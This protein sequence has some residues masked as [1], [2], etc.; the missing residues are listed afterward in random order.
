ME[1]LE[2]GLR[3][4]P[5]NAWL[6]LR[7][8]AVLA[9]QGRFGEARPILERLVA[10][11]PGQLNAQALLVQ[12]LLHEGSA[13]GAV[14]QLQGVLSACPADRRKDLRAIA[15]LVA[16]ALIEV[17]EILAA[18]KHLELALT[19]AGD[20]EQRE[21]IQNALRTVESSPVHSDVFRNPDTLSPP[22]EGLPAHARER[23]VQALG[24]AEEGRWSDAASAF[25]TLATEKVAVAERNAGL[26]RLWVLDD[27]EGVVA[28]RRYIARL[29]ETEEAVDLESLCQVCEPARD[30]DL[31]DHFQLIWHIR[32]R[33]RLLETLKAT[34]EVQYAGPTQLQEGE[35]AF[36]V[37]AFHLLDRPRP[38]GDALPEDVRDLPRVVAD[39]LVG[40]D[41]VMLDAYDDG[42][43]DDVR[44]RFTDLV[45]SSIPPAH[46]RTKEL[47]R[48][49][50]E[51]RSMASNFWRPENGDPRVLQRLIDEEG[52]RLIREVWP[53][54]PQARFRGRTPR[55]AAKAGDARVPLRAEVSRIEL[56]H[57]TAG[58]TQI[59]FGALRSELGLTEEPE[60]DP[61]SVA[62]DQVHITRLHR[63]PADR[64]DDDRLVAL[65]RRARRFGMLL[66]LEGAARVI[67]DR[68]DRV[69]AKTVDRLE[70]FAVLAET[71]LQRG[72]RDAAFAWM[73][74]GRQV[75]PESRGAR[76]VDWDMTVLRLQANTD[77]PEVWVP[78]LFRL[79]ERYGAG[80]Q[81]GIPMLGYLSGMGLIRLT[82]HQDQ[83][84]KVLMDDRALR[85]LLA[86]YGPK[87]ATAAGG[88]LWTPESASGGAAAPGGLWTPGA[89]A[90]APPGDKPKLIIPGR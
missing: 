3:K 45:G 44:M 18:R 28:L 81:T 49:S 39:V 2:E 26:C 72:E 55:Q 23:F 51:A 24:W 70:V 9:H 82:V 60:L 41:H 10:E 61:Q 13:A 17:H 20:N 29:G 89:S 52:A 75:D 84:G 65:Y 12:A 33:N 67:V 1:I 32:D 83:P 43:L 62:I 69:D 8:A 56:A 76:A 57:L 59:D 19:L 74:R 14:A 40:H 22:P 5:G 68:L 35:T 66:A 4:L 37:E 90:A 80:Q 78:Q 87:I 54:T 46:P 64:L 88:G 38:E 73:E 58:D 16:T 42:T 34:R 11:K 50:R 21:P 53:A 15:Q 47:G 77:P 79:L 30:D 86:Q 31:I 25:A 27:A 63:I 85:A 71:A 7:K 48:V 6:T 36:D